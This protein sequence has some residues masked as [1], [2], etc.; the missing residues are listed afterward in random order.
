VTVELDT[1]GIR[2]VGGLLLGAAFGALVQARHFCIMGAVADLVLFGSA[3]RLRVW[4]LAIATAVLGTQLL[5]AVELVPLGES[6]HL[7]SRLAVGPAVLGGLLFGFGMVLAGGCASRTLVRAAAGSLKSWIVLLVMGLAAL[8]AQ[9]G[10]LA[11]AHGALRELTSLPLAGDAEAQALWRPLSA[12]GLEPGPARLVGAFLLAG[13]LAAFVLVD[14]R[15]RA[16]RADLGTGTALGLLVVAGW[17]L[18]GW[19]A[20]DPFEPPAPA[21]LS[22]VAPVG[23]SLLLLAT[24]GASG[25]FGPAL[26]LGTLVGAAA[27]A[28]RAGGFR[29]EGFVSGAD[30]ARHLV[31]AALMGVGGTVAMGCTIGQGLSGI[32]TLSVTSLVATLA[33]VAGAAWALRYLES[34]RL[35]PKLTPSAL[36]RAGVAGRRGGPPWRTAS[37]GDM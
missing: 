30:L 31:G 18:T 13:A 26:V 5:A 11:P 34:G 32:S 6:G 33:I 12:L 3:R 36:L 19:L 8:T 29:L 4:L 9:L 15:L 17:L 28:P 7:A 16:S 37:G 21:S 14:G 24:G 20:A 1:D 2:L 23:Q 22:Y 25:T 27:A 35:L 10:L